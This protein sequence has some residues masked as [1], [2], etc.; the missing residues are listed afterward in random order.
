MLIHIVSLSLKCYHAILKILR[1]RE[2]DMKTC[3]EEAVIK[4]RWTVLLIMGIVLFGAYYAFDAISPIASYIINDMGISRAQAGRCDF[5]QEFVC[6]CRFVLHRIAAKTIQDQ[7]C[8]IRFLHVM[9][10]SYSH[11]SG[12]GKRLLRSGYP[13]PQLLSGLRW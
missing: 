1:D 11:L 5:G 12:H 3:V 4:L 10:D 9:P 2:P 13:E 8:L 7:K 6:F